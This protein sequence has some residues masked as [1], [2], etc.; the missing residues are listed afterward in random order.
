MPRG[1]AE[2]SEIDLSCRLPLLVLFI[3]A[4]KWLVIGWIFELIGSLKFHNPGFLADYSWLTYGR[5]HPAFT[6]AVVYGFCVQAGLGVMLWLFA[7]MGG[8]ALANRWLVTVGAIIWNLGVTVGIIGILA[9]DSTG[10][11]HLEMPGYASILVFIGYLAIAIWAAVT[12]HERRRR[13]LTASHWFLFTA[14]FWFPWI[15]STANLLL[16]SFP[17]RGVAQAVIAWWYSQNL[18]V[19]WLGLLGLGTLFYFIPKLSGRDLHNHYLALFAYWIL[20]MVAGW[21]GIPAS[22]PV[23]AWM[24]AI[25]AVASVLSVL[26]AIAV[27]LNVCHTLGCSLRPV[28][29]LPQ[30]S[31]LVFSGC[32]FVLAGVMRAASALLVTEQTLRLTWF[33]PAVQLLDYYGFFAMAGFGAIYV[34]LP[35]LLGVSFPWPKLVRVHFWVSAIGVLLVVVPFAICGAIEEARLD[36]A[37][38]FVTIMRSSM[39]FLRIS[40]MGDLL[41]LLGHVLFLANLTGAVVGFYRLRARTAYSVLT[42]DLFKPAGARP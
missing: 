5:V 2:V 12:L 21:G 26:G 35:R 25:S 1:L 19:T 18:L 39:V 10:F 17:V 11:E 22:A 33:G 34:I 28:R 6:N 36:A 20:V 37:Q 4:A 29:G 16:V 14:L 32:A 40:T 27:G 7:Q 38:P 42:A 13:E 30:L 23:P 9:G 3:S 41:I 15:Y 8:V 24:P 31:F